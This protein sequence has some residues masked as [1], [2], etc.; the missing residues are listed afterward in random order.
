MESTDP[1]NI[2]TPEEQQTAAECADGGLESTHD[3][4]V[5]NTPNNVPDSAVCP[6]VGEFPDVWDYDGDGDRTECITAPASSCRH[7]WQEA[8][9]DA[10]SDGVVQPSEIVNEHSA[11]GT[12]GVYDHALPYDIGLANTLTAAQI[13]ARQAAVDAVPCS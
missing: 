12:A 10:N 3:P 1:A 2:D 8:W 9:D 5:W 7:W 13:S 6:V 4:A 11:R